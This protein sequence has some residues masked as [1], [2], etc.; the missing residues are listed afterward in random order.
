MPACWRV[1]FSNPPVN[2]LDFMTV[3]EFG[4]IVER[5]ED[6]EDLRVLVVA[7]ANPESGV[8]FSIDAKSGM[9][10]SDLTFVSWLVRL[11][12][13]RAQDRAV[14]LLPR[15]R[16]ADHARPGRWPRPLR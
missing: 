1:V 16:H 12:S 4:E 8:T 3:L 2:L 5:V 14:P 6:R 15:R 7:R 9:G 13:W 10:E 11:R